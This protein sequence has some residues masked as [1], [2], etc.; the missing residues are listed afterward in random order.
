MSPKRSP[1]RHDDGDVG[2]RFEDL[3]NDLV[4]ALYL[5]K[6]VKDEQQRAARKVRHETPRGAPPRRDVQHLGDRRPHHLFGDHCRKRHEE[7][8]VGEL[9]RKPSGRRDGEPCLAGTT[10]PGE[11]QQSDVRRTEHLRQP[12]QVRISAEQRS[13]RDRQARCRSE[14]SEWGKILLKTRDGQLVQTLGFGDVL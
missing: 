7:H 5:L 1:R 9:G 3:G 11:C 2:R 13:R 12:R 8:T 4:S 10:R 6:V 14:S